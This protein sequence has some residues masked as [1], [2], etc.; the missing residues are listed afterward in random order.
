HLVRLARLLVGLED[1][2]VWVCAD[3]ANVRV[4]LFQKPARAGD[5]TARADACDEVC[6]A[7]FG[8][9]PDFRAGRAIVRFGV[10]GVR[11]LIRI[12]R[13]GRLACDALR[14]RDV[15]IG[16]AGF[17]GGGYDDH[18]CAERLQITHLLN[19]SLVGHHK[20]AAITFD[21]RCERKAD[22]CVARCRFD[23]RAAGLERAFA[24]GRFDHRA[25]DAILDRVTGIQALHLGEH[26]RFDPLRQTVQLDE[27]RV[28]D[29]FQYVL[30]VI[31]PVLR[32]NCLRSHEPRCF[33]YTTAGLIHTTCQSLTLTLIGAVAASTIDFHLPSAYLPRAL[34]TIPTDEYLASLVPRSLAG[35]VRSKVM[36]A[37]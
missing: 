28:P 4:L 32:L 34:T 33:S 1:R 19:R 21:G 9:F 12:E 6:D 11:V 22:A 2:A 30:F 20:D 27:R 8:L 10:G 36:G 37:I 25:P 5:R 15:M 23:D 18:V 3:D 14:G 7:P 26:G 35:W 29:K 24:L 17:G 31:H 16:R 13:I